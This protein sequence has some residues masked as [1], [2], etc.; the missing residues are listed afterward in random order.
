MTIRPPA[1]AATTPSST[2]LSQKAGGETRARLLVHALR[3][4]D[5][6]DAATVHDDDEVRDRHRFFLVVGHVHEGRMR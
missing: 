3:P 5:I 4:T 2:V 1:A 6:L